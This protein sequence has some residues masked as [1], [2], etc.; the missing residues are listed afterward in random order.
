MGISVPLHWDEL[1]K[2][3]EL[4]RWTLANFSERVKTGNTPWRDYEKSRQG[5]AAPI[6]ALAA[7]QRRR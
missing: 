6:R 3:P 1:G 2:L 5:L 7:V 4:P